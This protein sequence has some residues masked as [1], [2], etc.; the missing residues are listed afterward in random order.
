MTIVGNQDYKYSE[1]CSIFNE[2]QKT[3]NARTSQLKRWKTFINWIKPTKQIYRITE[4]F[5]KAKETTDGRRNNGGARKGAGAKIKM[6]EEFEY[7]LNCY[8]FCWLVRYNYLNPDGSSPTE[9]HFTNKDISEYFGLQSEDFNRGYCDETVKKEAFSKVCK[10][11]AEIRESWIFD[12]I[13]KM[14]GMELSSGIIAYTNR[15]AGKFEFRDDLLEEWNMR[16]EEY[17]K[18]K[19]CRSIGD[20]IERGLWLEMI[21][22][23]SE[24]FPQYEEVIKCKKIVL[25]SID[26]YKEYDLAEYENNMIAYNDRI[27]ESLM[28]YF[29]KKTADVNQDDKEAVKFEDYIRVIEKYV[30]I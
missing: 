6:Q 9:I 8:L 11:I 10:K 24:Y 20:V 3:G 13:K 29:K 1:L 7:V 27:V 5:E 28:E 30:R 25:D 15:K 4:V 14:N 17:C 12:K 19:E 26:Y 2:Q 21:K 18:E 22:Y 23:I 16:Q